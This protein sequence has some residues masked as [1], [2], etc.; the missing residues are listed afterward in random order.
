MATFCSPECETAGSMCQICFYYDEP[1]EER[2]RF[3]E[4]E[5]MSSWCYLFM[6]PTEG[7]EGIACKGFVCPR[8]GGRDWKDV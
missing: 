3:D 5:F 4:E 2:W 6:K 8:S 1:A 7:W